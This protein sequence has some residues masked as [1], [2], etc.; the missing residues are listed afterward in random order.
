MT[1][2]ENNITALVDAALKEDVGDL[3][4]P[5]FLGLGGKKGVAVTSLGFAGK[6]G[7]DVFFSLGPFQ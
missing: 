7:E 3:F 5:F 4:I 6:G 1:D 2:L